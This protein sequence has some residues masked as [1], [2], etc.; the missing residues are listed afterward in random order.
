MA[1]TTRHLGRT[2]IPVGPI[3][4]GGAGLGL[5]DVSD[6]EA[7]ATVHRAFERGI[8][9]LDTSPLYGESE[10]RVGLALRG[11]P[12]TEFLLS[13]KTGTHPAR[14]GDYSRDATLWSV[15]NSL[16]LLGVDQIDLLLVHDP[17]DMAPVMASGA[18]LDTLEALRDQGVVRWIGLGQRSHAAHRAAILSGRFDVVLTFNDFLPVRTTA[19]TSGLLD[20]AA[21][22]GVGVLNGSPLGLGLLVADLDDPAVWERYAWEPREREAARRYQAFCRETGVDPAGLALRFCGRE[23]RIH[24]TL[25]GARNRAELDHNLDAAQRA[26]PDAI[27]TAL[28]ALRLTEGQE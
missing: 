12:R 24:C 19:A 6:D 2:D 3:G 26:I 27:W 22:H 8:R 17:P 18:V 7:V 5:P 23:P 11:V 10:R 25:T 15:E 14:R 20:V 21:A 1:S 28:D 4:L 16:R 13:T 9:F